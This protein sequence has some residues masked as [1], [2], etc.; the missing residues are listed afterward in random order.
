MNVVIEINRF[1]AQLSLMH[2]EKLMVLDVVVHAWF[3]LPKGKGAKGVKRCVLVKKD[4]SRTPP[5]GKKHYPS[6]STYH[7]VSFG[8]WQLAV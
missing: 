8:V 5:L 6:Y 3:F 1:V 4:A 7:K 2:L